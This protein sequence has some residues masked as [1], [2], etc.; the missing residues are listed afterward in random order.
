M[1]HVY[2]DI[3]YNYIEEGAR[4]SARV[5]AEIIMPTLNPKSLLDVGCGRGAWLAEWRMAGVNDIMG[6]DGDY[7]NRSTLHVAVTEFEGRDLRH[8][9]DLRRTF[10]LVQSLEVAEHISVEFAATFISNLVRHGDVVMFSAAVP[11]QGGEDH[12]NEQPLEFWRKHFLQHGFEA[13]DVVRPHLVKKSQVAHWYKYNT[14]IYIH[15][16]ALSQVPA[17]WRSKKIPANLKIE[18]GGDAA[19]RLRR[20]IVRLLPRRIVDQIA[21]YNSVR[22]S[23]A[24]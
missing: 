23:R 12:I 8:S 22:I 14:L 19:W 3:F 7:V 6:I 20:A 24:L 4:T 10:D 2:S 17:D 15:P 16:R 11:G 5:V 13:Y 21:I 9:F 18:E 1:G